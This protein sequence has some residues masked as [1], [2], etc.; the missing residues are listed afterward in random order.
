MTEVAIEQRGGFVGPGTPGGHLH[1]RGRV[2]WSALNDADR[3]IVD[4]LFA[5]KRPV[6][7][8][9]SYRLTRT[10]PHGTETV[11]APTEAVPQALIASVQTTLD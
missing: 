6:D 7:T 10:G 2:A 3:A 11:D 4:A 5:A 9:V 8:N 1:M